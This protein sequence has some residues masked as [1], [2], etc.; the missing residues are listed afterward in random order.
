MSIYKVAPAAGVT[1]IDNWIMHYILR[2][3]A[4]QPVIVNKLKNGF[5][6]LVL[7]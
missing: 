7:N 4:L 1:L 3:A 2:S 5:I 6:Y